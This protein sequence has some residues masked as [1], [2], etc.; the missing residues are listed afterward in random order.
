MSLFRRG[1]CQILM[2]LRRGRTCFL[3]VLVLLATAVLRGQDN[4]PTVELFA[5]GGGSFHSSASRITSG[6]FR[7]TSSFSKTGRFFTGF[8]YHLAPRNALEAS[9]SYSPSDLRFTISD[10]SSSITFDNQRWVHDVAFNY[11]RYFSLGQRQYFLTG[12]LGFTE[13]ASPFGGR[14]KFAG[15][16]GG[17][18]DLRMNRRLTL[19]TEFRDFLTGHPSFAGRTLH[20][21]VP[22]V[23]L[24][25]RLW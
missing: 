17:G 12:G 24:V 8:R 1:Y 14:I 10:P 22:S 19:R 23:G 3:I 5:Q 9:Y 18:L 7:A 20:N 2:R 6:S 15:N 13:F 21:F 25:F 16:F 11:V 4:P